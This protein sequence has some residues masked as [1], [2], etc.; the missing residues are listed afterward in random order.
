MDLSGLLSARV[1]RR[2]DLE[3]HTCIYI[4]NYFTVF[5]LCRILTENLKEYNLYGGMD[6][7]TRSAFLKH[8]QM[9]KQTRTIPARSVK[10][11]K[12]FPKI[13]VTSILK[14]KSKRF[15]L[16]CFRVHLVYP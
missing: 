2:L 6:T 13:T 8:L 9:H 3:L 7:Y 15:T 12:L 10:W 14:I 16:W 4:I 1:D 11:C 5:I